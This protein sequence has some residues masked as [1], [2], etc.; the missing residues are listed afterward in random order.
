M[1]IS[2]TPSLA[3]LKPAAAVRIRGVGDSEGGQGATNLGS[4]EALESLRVRGR[5]R[6]EGTPKVVKAQRL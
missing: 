6:V 4:L 3:L 1:P 2:H 5:L